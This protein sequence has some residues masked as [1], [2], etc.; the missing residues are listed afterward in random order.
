[1]F[2]SLPIFQSD[3]FRIGNGK[4]LLK[5]SYFPVILEVR[6]TWG[7]VWKNNNIFGSMLNHTIL[8]EAVY[9]TMY[10]EIIVKITFCSI[11]NMAATCFLTYSFY[12]FHFIDAFFVTL[13]FIV[14]L[15]NQTRSSARV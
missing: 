4:M 8:F 11:I 1:M 6:S 10:V 14:R 12:R 9:I 5:I 3:L 13:T 7:N 2:S 15:C